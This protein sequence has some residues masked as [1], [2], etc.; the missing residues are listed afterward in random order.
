[1]RKGVLP[2]YQLFR[3]RLCFSDSNLT[4]HLLSAIEQQHS[5]DDYSIDNLA[6]KFWYPGLQIPLRAIA[7]QGM[8][9]PAV[10]IRPCKPPSNLGRQHWWQV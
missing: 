3:D 1:M 10:K 9:N 2:N 6:A 4:V 8:Q 7:W 5:D